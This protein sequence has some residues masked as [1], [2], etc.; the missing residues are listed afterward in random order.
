MKVFP[1]SI[2]NYTFSRYTGSCACRPPLKE[3]AQFVLK[4]SQ[5][6]DLR[7]ASIRGIVVLPETISELH[8]YRPLL[9]LWHDGVT[10]HNEAPSDD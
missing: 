10:S 2:Y 7:E 5:W 1:R 6:P 3:L 9:S 4:L 8:R